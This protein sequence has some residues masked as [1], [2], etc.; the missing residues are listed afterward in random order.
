MRM[1]YAAAN[2]L[3]RGNG[4]HGPRGSFIRAAYEIIGRTPEVR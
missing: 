2:G 3:W 1:D 4:P